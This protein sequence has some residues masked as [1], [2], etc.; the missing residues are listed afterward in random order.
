MAARKPLTKFD[1]PGDYAPNLTKVSGAIDAEF[2][3]V[4]KVIVDS[5]NALYT[6]NHIG[7]TA[8]TKRVFQ[9][10]TGG[11]TADSSGTITITLPNTADLSSVSVGDF[12]S[13]PDSAVWVDDDSNVLQY[14]IT[15]LTEYDAG[16]SIDA[17]IS[18]DSSEDSSHQAFAAETGQ[19]VEVVDE[20][21]KDIILTFSGTPNLSKVMVNNVLRIQGSSLFNERSGFKVKSVSDAN[22][23]ITFELPYHRSWKWA[24]N[25]SQVTVDVYGFVG[26]F[27]IEGDTEETTLTT[28]TR[29]DAQGGTEA[30]PVVAGMRKMGHFTEVAVS[31]GSLIAYMYSE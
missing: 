6:D 17:T 15:A 29:G 11:S 26:A 30:G 13:L 7:L 24:D 14:T 18:F 19:A 25:E 1:H 22:D 12:V 3:Q 2:G 31:A 5:T 20:F 16:N 27:C 4:A 10:F 9:S 28:I 23:T 21:E 8:S